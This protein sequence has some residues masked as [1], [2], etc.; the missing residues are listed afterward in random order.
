MTRREAAELFDGC[1]LLLALADLTDSQRHAVIARF[2][3]DQTVP[4][5]GVEMGLS[6]QGAANA[7]KNGVARLGRTLA[8]FRD[9]LAA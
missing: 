3:R 8:P 5:I 6:T 1:T 2:W 4:A 9:R 7:L